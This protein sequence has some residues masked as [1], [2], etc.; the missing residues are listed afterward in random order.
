[1]LLISDEI[2]TGLGHTGKLL[3]A[4]HD[5]VKPDAITLGKALGG[6]LLPVSLFLARREVM[7][8]FRP[9][10]HGSTFGGNPLAAAVGVEALDLLVDERL[11]ERSAE[12]GAYMLAKL[13]SLDSRL[14]REVRGRGLFIAIELRPDRIAARTFCERLMDHG[15]LTKDTHRNV[16]RFAPP[17]TVA[18]ADI[19]EVV[20]KVRATLDAFAED[21]VQEA[22]EESFPA[23][24]APAG[25]AA[26]HLG[27]PDRAGRG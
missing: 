24:D 11:V 5:G 14:I 6:G 19:D 23:S 1:M 22:S 10:D 7:D 21:R 16:V 2:Q 27:G 13:R 17:L 8:V 12:T 3:G 26:T 18:I 15:V 4:D 25:G 9:G 20:E